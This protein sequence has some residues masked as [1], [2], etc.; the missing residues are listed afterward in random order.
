MAMDSLAP[1]TAA[2]PGWYKQF[3]IE[4]DV[5]QREARLK[6][7]LKLAKSHS[8]EQLDALVRLAFGTKKTA[9]PTDLGKIREAFIAAD[10]TFPKSGND[11]ELQF[12]AAACLVQK[13]SE[14]NLSLTALAIV[15]TTCNG[16]R[17]TN[18]PM[19]LVA[20]ATVTLKERAEVNRQRPQNFT[21]GELSA[22]NF[23]PA[24]EKLRANQ[25]FEMA[26]ETLGDVQAAVKAA[27]A[28]RAAQEKKIFDGLQKHLQQKDEE[29]DLLWW[30]TGQHCELLDCSFD[31]VPSNA[32]PLVMAKELA[33]LSKMI[34]GPA[35]VEGLLSRVGLKDRKKIPLVS[36]LAGVS[37]DWARQFIED[38]DYSPVLAPMHFA[39]HRRIENGDGDDWIVNWSN[40]TG[41]KAEFEATP[42]K[43]ALAFYRECVLL[44][45]SA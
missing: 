12:L 16:A 6:G 43:L 29:L 35:S 13:L 8:Y 7:V 33:D 20:R 31:A 34:P 24:Q 5:E 26:V 40:V 17:T 23:V 15:T 2:F 41:I 4:E 25:S 1:L 18:L 28:E 36:A 32:F 42:L 21:L 45:W 39:L 11:Q 3:Q 37:L 10:E 38:D 22:L 14:D 30:L 9:A 27:F 19:D 44:K